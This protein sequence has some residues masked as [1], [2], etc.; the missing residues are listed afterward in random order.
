MRLLI[1]RRRSTGWLGPQIASLEADFFVESVEFVAAFFSHE[2][3]GLNHLTE[4]W[5]IG[6]LVVG[7]VSPH[8][9]P[10]HQDTRICLVNA[11]VGFC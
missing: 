6:V 5:C 11:G 9:P 1:A 8:S 7:F 2:F 3:H 4:V 10:G